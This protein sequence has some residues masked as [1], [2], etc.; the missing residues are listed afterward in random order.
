MYPLNPC[1]PHHPTREPASGTRTLPTNPGARCAY[2]VHIRHHNCLTRDRPSHPEPN[3]LRGPALADRGGPGSSHPRFHSP[4]LAAAAPL[5]GACFRGILNCSCVSAM[6]RAREELEKKLE[7]T[8]CSY[9]A[10]PLHSIVVQIEPPRVPYAVK[11]RDSR[12]D[13][14]VQGWVDV[15]VAGRVRRSGAR[16]RLSIDARGR[17][18]AS[19][20]TWLSC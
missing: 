11:S 10:F 16:T 12:A 20:A 9:L 7:R 15:G 4:C 2:L 6:W 19:S 13:M 17:C 5:T 14:N 1:Y 18:I 3:R 8:S